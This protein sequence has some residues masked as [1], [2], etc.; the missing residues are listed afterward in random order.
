MFSHVVLVTLCNF[1]KKKRINNFKFLPVSNNTISI[2]AQKK[3]QVD[4][5]KFDEILYE[6]KNQLVTKLCLE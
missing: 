3:K 4:L 1:L 5:V 6:L 2:Y